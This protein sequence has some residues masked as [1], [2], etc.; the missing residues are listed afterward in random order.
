[1]SGKVDFV[2]QCPLT[3]EEEARLGNRRGAAGETGRSDTCFKFLYWR[4]EL[5]IF[6]RRLFSSRATALRLAWLI[7]IYPCLWKNIAREGGWYFRCSRVATEIV[8]LN[9]R[10]LYWSLW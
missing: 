1:M 9:N 6:L 5:Q 8:S 10:H 2:A 7:R 4:L 3:S